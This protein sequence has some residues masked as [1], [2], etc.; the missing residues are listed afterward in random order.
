MAEFV[1]HRDP[2]QEKSSLVLKVENPTY[3][4]ENP[5][6]QTCFDCPVNLYSKAAGCTRLDYNSYTRDVSAVMLTSDEVQ[7]RIINDSL[8]TIYHGND[9][10]DSLM[11]AYGDKRLLME[12]WKR[13]RIRKIAAAKEEIEQVMA[14]GLVSMHAELHPNLVES[15]VVDFQA[16]LLD[17]LAT[18]PE[19]QEARGR[20]LREGRDD[21]LVSF[22]KGQFYTVCLPKY[23]THMQ[24][25]VQIGL[26]GKSFVLDMPGPLHDPKR[27][28]GAFFSF[29]YYND[30]SFLPINPS[31][32]AVVSEH[33]NAFA[34]QEISREIALLRQS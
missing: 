19:Y 15:L 13:L 32:P 21:S 14:R 18:L 10:Y 30:G 6:R 17:V 12:F 2:M 26:E 33:N 3:S 1:V 11:A 29:V 16:D 24:Q 20:Q 9:N 25:S 4:T 34:Y 22:K 27:R 23:D 28:K 5:F 7:C 31:K 8:N